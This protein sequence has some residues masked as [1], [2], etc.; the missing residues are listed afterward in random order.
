MLLL[1]CGLA[2]ELPSCRHRVAKTEAPH[3]YFYSALRDRNQATQITC[4]FWSLEHCWIGSSKSSTDPLNVSD[5][6]CDQV[7]AFCWTLETCFYYAKCGTFSMKSLQAGSGQAWNASSDDS[8]LALPA[9]TKQYWSFDLPLCPWTWFV[10]GWTHF[11]FGRKF[12]RWIWCA[13]ASDSWLLISFACCVATAGKDCCHACLYCLSSSFYL[14]A[15]S[16]L[17][18]AAGTLGPEVTA[19]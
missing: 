19:W 17:F 6:A 8:W 4:W 18:L 13:L 14:F 16:W 9:P 11:D 12:L 10:H 15:G 3:L 5:P 2:P 7:A 1:R